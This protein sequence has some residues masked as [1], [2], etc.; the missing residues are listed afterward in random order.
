ML[1]RCTVRLA[2]IALMLSIPTVGRLGG[3]ATAAPAR[4]A[5]TVDAGDDFFEPRN[6]TVRAGTTVQW[7]NMGQ[8]PHTVTADNGAFNSGNLNSGQGFSFTF[9]TAGTYPYYCEYHGSRGGQG[10]AGTITVTAAEAA[11]PAPAQPAAQA[12][13]AP[14]QPAAQPATQ[15][16]PQQTMPATGSPGSGSVAILALALIIAMFGLVLRLRGKRYAG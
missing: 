16:P 7:T 15:A 9:S 4:Q 8:R 1:Y 6:L 12:P 10:M 14:A 11:A 2:V 13:A 5:T 3:V